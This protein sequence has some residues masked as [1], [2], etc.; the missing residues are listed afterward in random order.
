MKLKLYFVIE[1][2]INLFGGEW[3]LNLVTSG[4][5]SKKFIVLRLKGS[6]VKFIYIKEPRAM[7]SQFN[8]FGTSFL[9]FPLVSPREK[10]KIHFCL[11]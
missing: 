10:E 4:V 11:S 1:Y 7:H 8:R 9:K 3:K 5:S 2:L 6:A